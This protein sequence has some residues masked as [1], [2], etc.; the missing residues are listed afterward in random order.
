ML[1]GMALTAF[2]KFRFLWGAVD[3]QGGT[4]N[5]YAAG[6]TGAL[7]TDASAAPGHIGVRRSTLVFDRA[8][9]S[10]ADDDV[11]IHF[12]WL[13]MTSGSP[14]DT[15]ITSD[16]TTLESAL[17]T[18]WG[19]AKGI[20]DPKTKLRE[21]R[22]HRAG[23]G[24]T[25]PNPAERTLV[26]GSMVAGSGTAGAGPATQ[27]CSVTFHTS[28]R[29]SWGRTYL[30]ANGTALDAQG[31]LTTAVVD[32]EAGAVNT[33]VTSAA[34]SDFYLVVVSNRLSAALNVEKIHVDDVPDVVR[35]RRLKH[36]VYRK[37]LP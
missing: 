36:V 17:L 33:L 11:T 6:S 3:W 27:A 1:S 2:T 37:Y 29:R 21:I 4:G 22:W 34:A 18:F 5:P 35:R 9:Y 31:R 10:P 23:P 7:G 25:P 32:I 12:D 19:T 14:D 26:L 24:I 13:N 8:S 30:P 20:V 28:V 15:W 16:Y